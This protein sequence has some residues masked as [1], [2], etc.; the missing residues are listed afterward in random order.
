MA[1]A[2]QKA[3]A[4]FAQKDYT[5]TERMATARVEAIERHEEACA[6][7]A[8]STAMLKKVVAAPQK[9]LVWTLPKEMWHKMKGTSRIM[10]L[11]NH[12]GVCSKRKIAFACMCL[13][14]L[15]FAFFCL[16]VSRHTLENTHPRTF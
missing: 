15:S 5:E 2:S 13:F 1:K 14:L 4:V 3:E 7:K 6:K 11:E 9:K 8:M 12:V 16:L 10:I